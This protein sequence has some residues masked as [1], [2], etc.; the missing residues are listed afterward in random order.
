MKNK[1]IIDKYGK[2]RTHC[3]LQCEFCKIWFWKVKRFISKCKNNYCTTKCM[4]LG[5]RTR[6]KVKCAYCGKPIERIISHLLKSKSKLYF[7]NRK[8]KDNAQNL[9]SGILKNSAYKNGEYVYRK[10]ALKAYGSKCELCGYDA[11]IDALVVHHINENRQHNK[12]LNLMVVCANCHILLT[13]KIIVVNS[14][15]D[16]K[17][18]AVA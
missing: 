17:H 3:Y 10:K 2:S 11:Y 9:D 14:R 12:L 6:V 15:K 8:C 5:Q 1:V 18:G 16:I 13:R 7:C 4:H